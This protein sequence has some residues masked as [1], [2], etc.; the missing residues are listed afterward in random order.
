MTSKYHQG[1]YHPKNI[2]KYAGTKPIFFRSAWE[3]KV[4][5]FFDNNSSIV[6]WA[7]EP[8]RIPYQNPF[9]GKYTVYVPDFIV[10]YVNSKNEQITEIIE[11]KPA[12][13]AI[14][15]KAKS[16]KS[17]A[18]FALNTYKWAAAKEFA[19]KNNINF[20]VMTEN[21]IFNNPKGKG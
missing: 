16:Q 18:A 5:E 3:V 4:M 6:S 10:T 12:K 1:Y 14:L 21:E 13:E 17:K 9:T 11:V 20:R 8:F 2:K 15:E 19:A 7:S